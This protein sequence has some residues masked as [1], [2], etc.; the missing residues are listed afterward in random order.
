MKNIKGNELIYPVG[1]SD[2]KQIAGLDFNPSAFA[3]VPQYYYMGADDEND[4]LP[5]DDAFSPLERELI[6]QVLGEDMSVRWEK[7]QTYMKAK[8]FVP[9]SIRIM[10]LGMELHL[11]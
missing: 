3:S 2:I 5:F 9:G 11:K 1:I 8:T 4:T 6:I 10:V 7:C